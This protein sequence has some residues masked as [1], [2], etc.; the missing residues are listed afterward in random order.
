[1]RVL[2][3]GGG[4]IGGG[5]AWRLAQAGARVTIA[6]AG[7]FGGETSS[8]GAGMLSP[9]GEF[10]RPSVWLELGVAGMRAFP[11][12]V[13]ELGGETKMPIDFVRCGCL[14]FVEPAAA[15]ARAEFQSAHGIFLEVRRDGLFYP[16]DAQV[17]PNHL[18]RALRCACLARGVEILEQ[19]PVAAIETS[20]YDAVVI[21][22]GAW[23]SQ[24]RATHRGTAIELPAVKPVKGHL[25][26]FD[27]TP[28]MLGPMLRRGHS[29]VLQRSNG[30]LLAGSNEED[31]GFDRTIDAATCAEIHA[32]AAELFPALRDAEP[33][34]RWTGLRPYC[35]EPQIRRVAGTN[36]WLA[37]GH[38]RN[39]ILL[40]PL[41]S[42]RI[43]AEILG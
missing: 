12:F 19:H 18:L 16:E 39:G 31:A 15:Q 25:I 10:D 27:L 26:G 37:Y 13:E 8:A 14:H 5:I 35:A 34:K 9:G 24:I 22:A 41:T 42:S 6:D 32:H 36:L 29:Y 7:R 23:S 30:F 2:I 3:A 17:D 11:S 1:M 40:T 4:L 38:F 33:S 21:A 43:S 28:G 20:D